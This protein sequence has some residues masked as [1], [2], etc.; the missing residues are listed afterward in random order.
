MEKIRCEHRVFMRGTP[1]QCAQDEQDALD[2][3]FPWIEK[4]FSS[5]SEAKRF[6]GLNSRKVESSK[7]LPKQEAQHD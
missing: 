7:M 5:I 6:N 3:T 1:E 2:N 4:A